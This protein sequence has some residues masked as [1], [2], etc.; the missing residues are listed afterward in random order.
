M[1]TSSNSGSE[2]SGATIGREE[3]WSRIP[4]YILGKEELGVDHWVMKEEV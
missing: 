2:L 1:K 4:E 3:D